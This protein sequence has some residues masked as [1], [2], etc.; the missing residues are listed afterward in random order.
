MSWTP[1]ADLTFEPPLGLGPDDR[2]FSKV[3]ERWAAT[4]PDRICLVQD[5][6]VTL[7]YGQLDQRA[8]AI[9]AGL[10]EMGIRPGDRVATLVANDLRVLYLGVA[11]SKL[12]AIEVPINPALVGAS[13]RH[14]LADADPRL[15]IVAP[16]FHEQLVAALPDG[17]A[18]RIV[19]IAPEGAAEQVTGRLPSVDEMLDGGGRD[20][21]T[22]DGVRPS[23]PSSIMY[24]SGTTGLPKGALLP[25]LHSYRIAERTAAALRLTGDDT[26]ISILP[27]F[28]GGGRY[29]NA[30]ACILAGARCG[31]VRR[32]S[33]AAFFDQAR[34]FGATAMHGV[35]SVGHFLLAQ[36][37]T[38][39]DRDHSITRGI[40][41]P[42]P[43][44][45]GIAMR[46]RFGIEVFQGYA[47]TEGNIS[48]LNLDGPAEA[49]G[50]AYPPY[51]VRIVDEED[52]PLP[53]GETGEI[54]VSSD[55]PW[56]TFSG[57]WNQPETSL[58]VMRNFGLHTGDAGYLDEDGYL[59][60]VDRIKDM[61]RRRGEN[62][63]AQTVEEAVHRA[64]GV[65]E[66]AA[67]PVPSEHGE[68]EIAVAVVVKPDSGLTPERIVDTCR[69]ELPRFAVPRYVRLVDALPMTETGKIQKFRLKQEGVGDAHDF[70][71]C[72]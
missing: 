72:R 24:T 65:V 46:E 42:R 34:A 8:G 54:V 13:M 20:F 56:S 1:P 5:D 58:E 29:M 18:G 57:Y 32:F 12:G 7:G 55:E 23:T 45:V 4:A 64:P 21:P 40:L 22:V 19:E 9:A 53:A 63:A 27:L 2:V 33:G 6:G 62:V 30:G 71:E 15:S 44:S 69:A 49:C 70:P 39:G 68:E 10:H 3:V 11:L 14:V 60:Y 47:S 28:H 41:A 52:R 43:D 66:V 17:S 36:E 67:Y 35:V 37:P 50:R 26:M 61:I 51:R 16:G 48:V 38:P 59:W 25:N 31:L